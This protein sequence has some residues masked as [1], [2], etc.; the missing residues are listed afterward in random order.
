MINYQ[1]IHSAESSIEDL[2]SIPQIKT[3]DLIKFNL[4]VAYF[5]ILVFLMMKLLFT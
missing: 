4:G 1:K 3:K 5:I 2:N